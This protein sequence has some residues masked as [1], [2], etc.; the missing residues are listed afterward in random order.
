MKWQWDEAAFRFQVTLRNWPNTL[1]VKRLWPQ[2]G[3]NLKKIP[4]ASIRSMVQA[5]EK[6]FGVKGEVED[7]ADLDDELDDDMPAVEI[8]PWS[9]G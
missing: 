1:V 8:V 9:D 7:E 6:K 5:Q 4:D 2:R 3:F